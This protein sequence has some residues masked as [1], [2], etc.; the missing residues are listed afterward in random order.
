MSCHTWGVTLLIVGLILELAAAYWVLWNLGMDERIKRAWARTRSMANALLVRLRL[1]PRPI[2]VT[3]HQSSTVRLSGTGGL[4]VAD[5]LT[6]HKG[7]PPPTSLEEAGEQIQLLQDEVERLRDDQK[8]E[9]EKLRQELQAEIRDRVGQMTQESF[10]RIEALREMVAE[11][12]REEI[13]RRWPEALLFVTGLT[14]GLFGT[15]LTAVC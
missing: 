14:F 10:E 8:A 2:E 9:L 4:S 13:R 3:G 11:Q 5:A 15:L 7:R 12:T 1:R 6:V